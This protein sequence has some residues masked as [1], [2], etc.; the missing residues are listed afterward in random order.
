MT[1]FFPQLVKYVIR[2]IHGVLLLSVAFARS[3][4]NDIFGRSEEHEARARADVFRQPEP[5]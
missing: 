3:G 1:A 4:A 2:L 5:S